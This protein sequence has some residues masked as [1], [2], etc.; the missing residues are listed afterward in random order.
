MGISIQKR[1]KI[2]LT[3]PKISVCIPVY[4]GE[5]TIE[6]SVRSVMGQTFKDFEIVITDDSP[7]DKSSRIIKSIKDERIHYFLNEKNLG[8]GGNLN[9]GMRKASCD[10]IFYLSQDDLLDKQALEKTYR[11]FCSDEMIG[12]VIRPYYW[13]QKSYK[14]PVRITKQFTKDKIVSIKSPYDMIANVIALSD[15]VSGVGLRK[16]YIKSVFSN[17]PFI[18]MAS[19]VCDVLK[20][21]KVYILKDN[22]V[23]VRIGD[24]GATSPK[25]YFNSPMIVWDDMLQKTYS[26]K[27][28]ENLKKYLV[29]H[30]IANNYIGLV[31]IKNYGTWIQLFREFYYMIKLRKSNL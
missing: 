4:N 12:I 28:F 7:N 24:N 8:C 3:K 6:E 22:I 25:V 15:Q 29:D 26:E 18:E 30:F 17:T 9:E 14:L 13:F 27:E 1:N 2:M 5:L 23:A 31:Q 16:K 19:V 20:R 11:A 10:L 21:A